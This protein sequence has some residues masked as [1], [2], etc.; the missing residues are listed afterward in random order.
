VAAPGAGSED[1]V[2]ALLKGI[3]ADFQALL[4]QEFVLARQEAREDL[5]RVRAPV[6]EVVVGAVAVAFGASLLV[7]GVGRALALTFGWPPWAAYVLAGGILLVLGGA[8]LAAA[9]QRLRQVDLV[10][11]KTVE[12][13]GENVEWLRHRIASGRTS[14]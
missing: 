11:H 2:A 9:R 8:V 3:V 13:I 1:S 7:L 10:P 4:R 6:A 12:T 5:Q 14:S